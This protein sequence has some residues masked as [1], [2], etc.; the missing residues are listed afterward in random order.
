[1]F[2]DEVRNKHK[3]IMQMYFTHKILANRKKSSTKGKLK[4][5]ETQRLIPSILTLQAVMVW[6]NHC[7]GVC[8]WLSLI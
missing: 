3:Q 2:I 7:T 1:M 6:A 4:S 5:L 8:L